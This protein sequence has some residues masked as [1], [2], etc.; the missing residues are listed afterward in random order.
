[1]K[2]NSDSRLVQKADRQPDSDVDP[3]QIAD[4][5]T[6]IRV[7]GQRHRRLVKVD[8]DAN[9]FPHVRLLQTRTAQL[10]IQILREPREKREVSDVTFLVDDSHRLT[11]VLSRLC[12][13]V[14]S[15]RHG[16]RNVPI[17]VKFLV[18]L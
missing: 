14:R 1:M 10:T 16:N 5:E 15:E 17:Y 8:P 12:L 2:S 4:D 11:N 6:V 13:R 18:E 3:N 9:Q 7:N